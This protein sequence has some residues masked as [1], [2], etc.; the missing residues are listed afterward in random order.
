MSENPE[1]FIK[2][3][4]PC[5]EHLYIT[6]SLVRMLGQNFEPTHPTRGVKRLCY[7]N[8]GRASNVGCLTQPCSMP[9]VVGGWI[10]AAADAARALVFASGSVHPTLDCEME[11]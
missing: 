5:G 2:I 3:F 1:P 9:G 6:G 4:E 10:R 8:G 7:L 11:K